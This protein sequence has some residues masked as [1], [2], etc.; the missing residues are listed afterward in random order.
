MVMVLCST[1]IVMDPPTLLSDS[2]LSILTFTRPPALRRQPL[3]LLLLPALS[4]VAERADDDTTRL[5]LDDS[6]LHI[7]IK[8]ISTDL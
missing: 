4:T 5:P 8:T 2:A 3:P 7:S 6:T 1:L